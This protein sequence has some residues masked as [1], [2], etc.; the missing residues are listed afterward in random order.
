MGTVRHHERI[1]IFRAI[2]L[3]FLCIA[4]FG[5][6]SCSNP[7][8]ESGADTGSIAFSLR[9]P[10]AGPVSKAFPGLEGSLSS[11][12]RD[13]GI[14]SLELDVFD[15][16]KKSIA[17]GGPWECSLGEGVIDGIKT[18]G[19]R[20]LIVSLKNSAGKLIL[21]GTKSGITVFA[22]RTS[23]VGEIDIILAEENRAPAAVN[24]T[25]TVNRGDT[26]SLLSSGDAS[27]LSNDTDPDGLA[28]RVNTVPLRGPSHGTL[29]LNADGTFSYTNDGQSTAGDSFVYEISDV[30]GNKAAATVTITVP[31]NVLP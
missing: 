10:D 29:V 17:T 22:G 3:P 7:D 9:F 23:D 13:Y 27:V 25:A 28:L 14:T 2:I 24:D 31:I 6:F 19:E 16:T 11:H 1:V 5:L 26:V 18:G 4:A 20:S 15:E 12:C 8:R 30:F 21:L